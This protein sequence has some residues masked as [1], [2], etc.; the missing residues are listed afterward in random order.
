VSKVEFYDGVNKLG[1][2]TT[3]PYSYNWSNPTLGAHTLKAK[4][5]GSDATS[6]TSEPITVI[7]MNP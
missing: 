7:V 2:D 4:A 6:G 3:A 5:I 1:E